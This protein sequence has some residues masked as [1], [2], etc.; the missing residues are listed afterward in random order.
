M[1]DVRCAIC[2]RLEMGMFELGNEE[3]D[4]PKSVFLFP[5]LN[6]II[7]VRAGWEEGI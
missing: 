4:R 3:C 2:Q 5:G 7:M 6:L 1:C